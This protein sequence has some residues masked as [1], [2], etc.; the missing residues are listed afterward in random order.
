MTTAHT[1]IS[2]DVPVLTLINVFTV[3]PDRQERLIEVLDRATE[4][5]MRHRPGFISANIHRGLDGVTVTNYAQWESR[6]AFEAT[7]A[8]PE[9]RVHMAE[10]AELGSYAPILYEI[11]SV[12]HA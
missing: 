12:H 6:E 7:M 2:A 11:A 1:I 8:D 5:V 4:D 9:A 10:A 3:E